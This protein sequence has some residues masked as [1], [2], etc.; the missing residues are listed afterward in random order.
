MIVQLG[1]RAHGRARCAHGIGLVDRDRG[2]NPLDRVDLRLVHAVEELPRVRAESLDVA[3]LPFRV[4]RVED[5]RRLPGAGD[6]G[7]HDELVQRQLEREV[8]EVVL[9][10]APDDDRG[11]GTALQ[12]IRI[13]RGPEKSFPAS[14]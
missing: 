10:G 7:H 2:R 12:H 1:H 5:E 6:A 3:P 9:A 14:L 11:G 8:L 4:E 13:L